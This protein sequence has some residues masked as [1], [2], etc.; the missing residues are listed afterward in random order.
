MGRKQFN[1][2]NDVIKP[3]SKKLEPIVDAGVRKAGAL[4]EA[5]K[6]GGS[7]RKTGLAHLHKTCIIKTIYST[8]IIIPTKS[9]IQ[10]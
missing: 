1:F 7:V 8:E 3:V 5:Y 10:S 6:T 9:W 2:F 4:I